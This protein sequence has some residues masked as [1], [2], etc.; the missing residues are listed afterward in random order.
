MVGS[1]Q[2]MRLVPTGR[3]YKLSYARISHNTSNWTTQTTEI[4][5]SENSLL[6]IICDALSNINQPRIPIKK[7][8]SSL[9][10][11]KFLQFEIAKLYDRE[12]S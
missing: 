6:S 7:R 12:E 9:I 3:N 8:L 2:K 10:R 11:L 1:G 5:G 4:K